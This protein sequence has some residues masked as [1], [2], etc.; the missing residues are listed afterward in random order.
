M[1][2]VYPLGTGSLWGNNKE[3]RYSLRSIEKFLIGF[4]NV[5]IVGECPEWL[6]SVI[7]IPC[8][9][10]NGVNKEKNIF[11]KIMAACRDPRLSDDFF[12]MNDDHFLL[13]AIQASA[14]PYYYHGSLRE[15]A[16]S[17]EDVYY[18]CTL[19]NTIKVLRARNLPR[20][21]FDVHM[22]I[23]YNKYSFMDVVSSYDWTV[24]W[25]YAIKSLYCN[26]LLI[27]GQQYADLKVK[28]QYDRDELQRITAGRP[29]FSINDYSLVD[30]MREFIHSHYPEQSQFEKP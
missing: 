13:H 21:H 18:G 30:D 15:K 24:A 26:T 12:F 29:C 28:G 8:R 27:R 17:V 5:F 7:H 23:V 3:L 9:D 22:P 16:E 25:G 1:D 2:I 14:F 10:V 4:H 11:D 20:L 6:Q 19:T